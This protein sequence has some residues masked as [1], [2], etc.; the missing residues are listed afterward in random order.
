MLMFSPPQSQVP[1]RHDRFDPLP[2]SFDDTD[3]YLFSKGFNNNSNVNDSTSSKVSMGNALDMI[4]ARRRAASNRGQSHRRYRSAD[5]KSIANSKHHNNRNDVE[6]DENVNDLNNNQGFY[7]SPNQMTHGD[8]KVTSKNS[9]RRLSFI[10]N[11]LLF[12]QSKSSKEINEKTPRDES[13]ASTKMANEEWLQSVE[14]GFVEFINFTIQ[15]QSNHNSTNSTLATLENKKL[16]AS[17]IRQANLL[18]HSM[19]KMKCLE[20]INR[21]IEEGRITIRNDRNPFQDVGLQTEIIQLLNSYNSIWL[22]LGLE[23]I[24]GK[25]I[26]FSPRQSSTNPNSSASSWSSSDEEISSNKRQLKQVMKSSLLADELIDYKHQHS[27]LGAFDNNQSYYHD[28]QRHFIRKFLMLVLF[29]DMAKV[30]EIPSYPMCLFEISTQ[31]NPSKIKTSK[32]MLKEFARLCLTEGDLTSHLQR[33]GYE[34]YHVQKPIEEVDFTVQ[35]LQ[36]DLRNGIILSRLIECL[37]PSIKLCNSLRVP[38]ISRLQQIHNVDEL[39]KVLRSHFSLNTGRRG[40][41]TSREIVDGH[42][43]K[44]LALLW[45]IMSHWKISSLVNINN[46]DNEVERIKKYHGKLATTIFTMSQDNFTNDQLREITQADSS[47]ITASIEASLLRW[48]QS[49]CSLYNIAITD[50]TNS[51]ANGQA[52]SLLI[53]YYHPELIK[54]EDI[55]VGTRKYFYPKSSLAHRSENDEAEILSEII[56]NGSIPSRISFKSA[57]EKCP[58]LAQSEYRNSLAD[59]RAN[60][61]TIGKA[62]KSLGCVP[63]LLPSFDS[64]NVPEKNLTLTF[65]AYLS[66]RLLDTRKEIEAVKSIQK[67]WA[68]RQMRTNPTD[69]DAHTRA[70][71]VAHA[72]WHQGFKQRLELEKAKVDRE[73][74]ASPSATVS[75]APK[76]RI[77]RKS[78]NPLKLTKQE[79]QVQSQPQQET[80]IQVKHENETKEGKKIAESSKY[81]LEQEEIKKQKEKI[82]LQRKKQAETQNKAATLIQSHVRTFLQ[83]KHYELARVASL[84]MHDIE[85]NEEEEEYLYSLELEASHIIQ[86]WYKSVCLKKEIKHRIQKRKEALKKKK[87]NQQIQIKPAANQQC[88]HNHTHFGIAG[89]VLRTK[90]DQLSSSLDEDPNTLVDLEKFISDKKNI[91]DMVSS[92]IMDLG[93]VSKLL[94]LIDGFLHDELYQVEQIERAANMICDIIIQLSPKQKGHLFSESHGRSNDILDDI[95]NVFVDVLQFC[96]D[97]P[98]VFLSTFRNFAQILKVKRMYH[99]SSEYLVSEVLHERL[100]MISDIM[101]VKYEIEEKLLKLDV[102]SSEE[103]NAVSKCLDEIISLCDY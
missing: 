55:G 13:F 42:R 1:D 14:K 95:Q 58:N 34:V 98:L 90:L 15:P 36:S 45:K 60:F 86:R 92:I 78:S 73:K 74:L 68:L 82:R 33:F 91:A 5:T 20:I 47:N 49:V 53:H 25:K 69:S 39:L 50:F 57:K 48:C 72:L 75:K 77:N 54:N 85:E 79:L 26:H 101:K 88:I 27:K 18:F 2:S 37:D 63:I 59:E 21:E 102:H 93:I 71:R 56:L 31:Y 22:K 89:S 76:A 3:R 29:L 46:L 7:P 87:A 16:E 40:D 66:S 81:I 28:I 51:L 67:L 43:E 30:N 19:T 52:L 64:E 44:T 70:Q 94:L 41:I 35:K 4:D 96:R 62:C 83:R 100:M 99:P 38:A 103:M 23:I 10:S 84:P 32:S 97:T 9:K 12:N 65:L 61:I 80:N 8:G 24:L 6:N 17:I 11:N